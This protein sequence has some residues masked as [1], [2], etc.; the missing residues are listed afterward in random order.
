MFLCLCSKYQTLLRLCHIGKKVRHKIL[1]S[2]NIMIQ[3][4]NKRHAYCR[5]NLRYPGVMFVLD[6]LVGF[7]GFH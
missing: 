5:E 3:S 6:N 4:K 2:D 7:Q 1:A